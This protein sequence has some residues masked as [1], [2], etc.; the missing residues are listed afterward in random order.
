MYNI[1]NEM[2]IRIYNYTNLIYTTK[3]IAINNNFM[4]LLI[5]SKSSTL[6]FSLNRI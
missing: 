3:R 2:F 6:Y 1:K 5:N 4:L